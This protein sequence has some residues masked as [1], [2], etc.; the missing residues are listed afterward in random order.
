LYVKS[1]VEEV[2]WLMM[3][4]AATEKEDGLIHNR[5]YETHYYQ[6]K[7][8]NHFDGNI[9]IIQGG[10]TFSAA[11]ILSSFLKGQSNVTIVGE[12][13]GGGYYGNS[14][15]HIPNIILPNTKLQVRLPMFR[16]V[17]DKT[18]PKGYG[19]MPDVEIYP[20]VE[21]VRNGVDLKMEAVRKM[22]KQ[23]KPL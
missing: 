23:Q 12:E 18:R 15:M 17:M 5:F 20:S 21:A 22:I 10:Y 13:S 8:T 16:Y 1:I 11:T 14:A 4:I 6:P 3:H 7:T 19:V 2:Y 9:Y